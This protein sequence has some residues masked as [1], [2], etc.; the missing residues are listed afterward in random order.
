MDRDELRQPLWVQLTV[1]EYEALKKSKAPNLPE[2]YR[3]NA[4]SGGGGRT[5]TRMVEL[6][7]D[8]ADAFDERRATSPYG[9]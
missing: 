7:V 3:Y 9:G 6:H 4:C 5:Q 8:D 1:E 2:G